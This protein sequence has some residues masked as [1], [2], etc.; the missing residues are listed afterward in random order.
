MAHRHH[1][2]GANERVDLTE[3]HRLR[4]VD[5]TSRLQDSE[6]RLSVA[7]YLRTLVGIDRVL[8]RQRVQPELLSHGGELLF[9]GLVESYPCQPVPFAAGLVGFLEGGGFRRPSA[10]YVDGV[11]HYHVAYDTPIPRHASG[12]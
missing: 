12:V 6:Q 11:V 10:V 7:F 5:V 9:G 4:L 2:V 8:D 1:E 3:L